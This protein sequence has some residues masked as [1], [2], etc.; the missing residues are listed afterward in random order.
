M[1]SIRYTRRYRKQN[2]YPM[3]K[4]LFSL[5]LILAGCDQ[6][7]QHTAG[8]ATSFDVPPMP[9]FST[10]N[11]VQEKKQA[12]FDYLLPL[13]EEANSRILAE[14]ALAEKWLLEPD[15]LST[16]EQQELQHLLEKYRITTDI[17]EQQQ[18]LLL[19]R[20]NAIPPSLVLAQAANESAWGTSRFAR[21]GN[22]LFGQWCFSEGC[23]LIPEGRGEDGRHEVR[24]FADPLQ[25][26]ESY[27][28]N[29]NSHPSYRQ[30][31]EL[32]LQELEQQ[33]YPSG[34]TLSQGLQSYSERGQDYI[35]EIQQMIEFNQLQR[36][37][38]TSPGGDNQRD[39]DSASGE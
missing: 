4:I 14:R 3:K 27:M 6:P 33:G 24:A 36:F 35:D 2:C 7:D 29:L 31:R 38:V 17:P 10:I 1:R 11:D 13:V 21:D 12:F 9:D 32:R 25:S 16:A 37:D 5:L 28:R 34:I 23:G 30:L 15:S 22:N 26:I 19:R 20:V 18:D 39:S 8:P